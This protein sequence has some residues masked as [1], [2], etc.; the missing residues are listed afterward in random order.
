MTFLVPPGA[1]PNIAWAVEGFPPSNTIGGTRQV[2]TATVATPSGAD[3]DVVVTVTAAGMTGTPKDVTVTVANGDTVGDVAGKLAAAL[4]GDAGVTAFFD[5]TVAGAV[6]T[7]TRKTHAAN[8]PAMA[9]AVKTDA[10]N[11]GVT[12]TDAITVQGALA[13]S[14]TITLAPEVSY[15]APPVIVGVP[16]HVPDAAGSAARGPE[17]FDGLAEAAAFHIGPG[18]GTGQGEQAQ[19]F[20]D[21][22][23]GGRRGDGPQPF[24]VSPQPLERV[25]QGREIGRGALGD[26]TAVMEDAS[27]AFELV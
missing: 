5:V 1:P 2:M 16:Q 6:V 20:R 21:P 3:G 10:S 17:Q 25:P 18:K 19:V 11:T 9:V 14:C 13:P 26:G 15:A 12:I 22:F 4:V 8:D 7:L 27:R 23:D 24:G